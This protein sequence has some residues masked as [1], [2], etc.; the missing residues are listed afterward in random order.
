VV[1]VK[2]VFLARRLDEKTYSAVQSIYFIPG[3]LLENVRLGIGDS[4]P[5]SKSGGFRLALTGLIALVAMHAAFWII[6]Q[7]V[8]KLWLGS[9]SETGRER[10]SSL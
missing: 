5:T 7:P 10:D 9:A 6:T 8:N 1:V 4:R 3:S 2:E